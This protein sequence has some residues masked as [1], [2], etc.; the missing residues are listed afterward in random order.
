[1]NVYWCHSHASTAA[2][3]DDCDGLCYRAL[4]WRDRDPSQWVDPPSW[5]C[6][7]E[8]VFILSLPA[9]FMEGADV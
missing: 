2:G 7:L 6:E 1:M 5:T 4:W 8:H 9:G 3:T